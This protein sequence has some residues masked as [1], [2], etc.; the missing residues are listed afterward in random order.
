MLN[1]PS[2]SDTSS[3]TRS[4]SPCAAFI[5]TRGNLHIHFAFY[6]HLI[7]KTMSALRL[8]PSPSPTRPTF[9]FDDESDIDMAEQRSI[10]LSSPPES[11]R[12]SRN[13][14]IHV[15][16]SSLN[17]DFQVTH[18]ETP[19]APEA[20]ILGPASPS[21]THEEDK[22]RGAS[23][24]SVS[25]PPM[26]TTETFASPSTQNSSNNL[27]ETLRSPQTFET[28]T[29]FKYPPPP[30]PEQTYPERENDTASMISYSSSSSR[31]ARP[32]SKLMEPPIGP[33]V[34]G[35]ALVD[36]NHLVCSLHTNN[37]E[38]I[39]SNYVDIRSARR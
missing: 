27:D 2:R 15:G 10:S 38:K 29:S 23:A 8:T 12:E 36:F 3:A 24:F 31:K 13:P 28:N 25:G 35:I 14:P 30:L 11:R 37:Y 4:P 16:S 19:K 32:E 6:Y 1:R 20:G 17:T 22:D 7:N 5:S 34:P 18:D 33:I 26:D 21:V 9:E 39:I